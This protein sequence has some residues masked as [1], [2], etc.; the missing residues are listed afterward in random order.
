[1][2]IKAQVDAFTGNAQGGVIA[3]GTFAQKLLDNDMNANM[4]RPWKEDD[5]ERADCGQAF[6]TNADGKSRTLVGNATLRK[7]EWKYIDDEVL[8][9]ARERHVGIADLERFG[10]TKN[11][12]NGMA[13]TVFQW[14][15]LAEFLSAEVTMDGLTPA[16]N[17]R[18][19]Y[20]VKYI[21]LPIVHADFQINARVLAA[22]RKTGTPID[23]TTAEEAGVVVSEKLEDMLFT[24]ITYAFGGGTIRSY[25][26][27]SGRNTGSLV[28]NWDASG[29]TGADILNDVRAMKQSSI[30]A[31]HYGSWILYIPTA[32]ET[33]LDD[34]FTT[35]YPITIRQRILEIEGIKEIKVVDRLTANNV[36][37][38]E[39]RKQTVRLLKGLAITP[40][41][42]STEGGLALNYKVM[43]IQI[44]QIR[45]DQSGKSGVTHYTGS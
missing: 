14:E 25:I 21:P 29:I 3:H 28:G 1:M 19:N 7:D 20:E 42:W 22:S 15:D 9:A 10:L 8:E 30:N 24:D 23:T 41:E 45:A 17:D 31:R 40:L 43:T 35:N 4:L 12:G 37:L 38:V 18:P 2:G 5:P 36:L 27:A 32:Y 44:P 34:N 33:V 13:M 39:L 11:L 6:I 16:K 26:N